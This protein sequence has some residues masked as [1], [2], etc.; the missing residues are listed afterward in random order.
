MVVGEPQILAQVK[1]A[2]ELATDRHSTGP[3]TTPDLSG[4]AARGQADDQRNVDQRKRVSIPSVA[5]A[6]FA[7][8]SSS[9]S[10]TSR[11]WSS[12]PAKWPKK[13]SAILQDQGAASDGHQPQLRAGPRS[14]RSVAGHAAG[15]GGT[16]RA[17]AAADLVDQHHR[18]RASR[19]SRWRCY[20]ADRARRAISATCSSST[21]RCRATSS[22]PSATAL[23]V[24]LYSID[25]LREACE[26]N[27]QE[28]DKERPK[29]T[30]DRRAGNGPL[31]GRAEP[32]GHGS[33]HPAAASKAGSSTRTTSCGGCSTSCP[34][35]PTS[36]ASEV[37]QAFDRLMN[38]LLHPPLES[39]RDEARQGVPHGLARS[40]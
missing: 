39:L 9:V 19:S 24:Y 7:S 8:Q 26:R 2:Y 11:S 3:L 1:Q 4:R 29:A 10:T 23:N 37:R 30:G 20:R 40:L 6:D 13:R 34:S 12:A 21:W 33:D 28:R 35:C 38:K 5:V 27:R 32:S 31:H 25:D 16:A 14:G 17:L 36:R 18:G 22:R 15:V